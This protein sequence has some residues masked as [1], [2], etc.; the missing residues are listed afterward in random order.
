MRCALC[1]LVYLG[2]SLLA[3]PAVWTHG[4]TSS[5]Y[6]AGNMDGSLHVWLL[7][8]MS[9]A[10]EHAGN[11]FYT[12][13]LHYPSGVNLIDNVGTQ[14]L[15]LVTT[16]ITMLWGPIASWNV[17]QLLGF[18]LSATA[19][20][21]VLQRWTRWLPAAFV[22]GLLYGFSPYM[23]AV[24]VHLMIYVTPVPP[25]VLWTMDRIMVRRAG[26]AWLNGLILALLL[27]AQFMIST[28]VFSST[29]VMLAIGTVVVVVAQAWRAARDRPRAAAA[30]F[31]GESARPAPGPA[32][33]SVAPN[34]GYLWRAGVVAVAVVCV[35]I[36]YPIWMALAGPAHIVGPA[37]PVALLRGISTDLLSPIVPTSNQLFSF[38]WAGVGNGLVGEHT[39]TSV[40]PDLGD[41]G[42][43]LGIPM[44]VLVIAG[45][46]ALWRRRVV[47][48]AVVMAAVALVL[49][50]GS[51]LHI[52]GRFVRGFHL[53]FVVL[54]HLPL[55]QS[56]AAARYVL[57]TWMFVA[58]ALAVVLDSLYA[59][60]RRR[61]HL[62]LALVAVAVVA[63]AALFPL[64]PDW[65]YPGGPSQV[66]AWFESSYAQE[67][68]HG[69]VLLTYP[70]TSVA[71]AA[72][73][74]WQAVAGMRFKMPAGYVISP[75]AQRKATFLPPGTRAIYAELQC[76]SGAN[77]SR[78]LPQ[79]TALAIRKD[80]TRMDIDTVVVPRGQKGS[81]CAVDLFTDAL[82]VAPR[83]EKGSEVWSG[84]KSLMATGSTAAAVEVEGG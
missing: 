37:Q 5:M 36:A 58:L 71:D 17:L 18:P 25:L 8:E 42:T 78:G 12:D 50:A 10:V 48:F 82:G 22:G 65:P 32:P 72:P 63:A 26:S 7:A 61:V 11:P 62:L 54:A 16:P 80:L 35:A 64:V 49:S 41:N 27:I 34:W 84:V 31:F 79:A 9:R 77:L 6:Y 39:A 43:Y 75:A 14:L 55:F 56:E 3:A 1:V 13:W 15:G 76:A 38:G 51:E 59:A 33:A 46:A 23:T 57:Y 21:F 45:A 19:M 60:L 81:R 47:R 4:I 69:S 20:F 73:M 67:V 70:V 24:S 40:V 29:I 68:P 44:I 30:D 83:S 52:D 28:E 53:P 74:L 66:P 2:L